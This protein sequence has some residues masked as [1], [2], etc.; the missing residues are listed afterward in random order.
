[1]V[2]H[3]LLISYLI[4]FKISIIG[5]GFL[6]VKVFD[7]NFFHY[8]LGIIGLVGIFFSI[9][10]SALTS[11]F[12]AH[13]YFHNLIFHFLGILFF[14][15]F[16]NK[17]KRSDLK[18]F[19]FLFI[20]MISAIYVS[21]NH[22][23]F[24]YYHLTYALNLSEN[25]FLIGMG[26]FSHGYRTPSSIFYFHSLFFLP[27]IKFFLFHSGPYII[28]FFFNTYILSRIREDLL[29][30]R[31]NF[32]FFLSLLFLTFVNIVF[33]RLGEHGADKS[34][35]ILLLLIFLIFFEILYFKENKNNSHI[36]LIIILTALA[37]SIKVLY[38]IYFILIIFLFFIKKISILY[39]KKNFMFL[40]FV[41]L[42][43][44]LF[45]LKSFLST[46]CLV[47][48]AKFTC[49]EKLSWSVPK[50]EVQKLNIHYEWWA[51]AGGD[52]SY[53]YDLP[54][55]EYIKDFNWI[56]NWFKKHFF[57]K[58]TDTLGGIVLI[59]IIF[60]LLFSNSKNF[61]KTFRKKFFIYN[62]IPFIFIIEWFFNHPA[63]R[64]GGYVLFSLPI[65]I[66]L[67]HYLEQRVDG[68]NSLTKKTLT[69]LIII[70]L[71]FNI[72]NFMRISKEI[73]QYGY[74]PIKKPFFYI[75]HVKSKIIT[76][77]DGLNIYTP[78]NNMCWASK[79][80]CSYNQNV[81]L[82]RVNGFYVIF[83]DVK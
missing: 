58:V 73:D 30:K 66:F 11:F 77:Y 62:L 36:N 23:D 41:G 38:I 65:F 51:K 46:G 67:S 70:F 47:Y 74:E 64:Y 81:I 34:S 19:V 76:H 24:P 3:I 45:I 9:F 69:I 16:F 10:F 37:A 4:I 56:D 80:P 13:D 44:F 35:Q 63:M 40:S 79:T 78:N 53:K 43:S 49:Y 1:M 72:R 59:S 52:S 20:L 55:E 54:K 5:Y 18:I 14:L 31:I 29:T 8:N 33:Y 28:M 50:E 39:L 60:Y 21:K 26:S 27:G 7:Q 68:Y 15:I 6:F 61:S 17:I 22:D 83:K 32:L 42:F 71:I 57:G 25:G 82:K 12:I 48:P 2:E 75:P